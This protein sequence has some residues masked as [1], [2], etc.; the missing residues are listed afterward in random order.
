MKAAALLFSL[1]AAAPAAAG[2]KIITFAPGIP[3]EARTRAVESRGG[4]VLK[5]FNLIN[6][7]LADMPDTA[8]GADIARAPGVDAA[9]DD[10]EIY[11]LGTDA[12][13]PLEQAQAALDAG[14]P[15]PAQPPAA[16]TPAA[17]AAPPYVATTTA[18]GG[19]DRM[20]W[21]AWRLQAP[22]AWTKARGAGARVAVLDT[23]T[24]CSH[25]D[26]AAA[27]LPGYNAQAPG[28]EPFDDG[29]H[30]THVSGIIAGALN[31][32]G[33]VGLAP[34]ARIIPVKVLN[35]SGTGKIS[36]ILDGMEWAVAQKPDIMNMSLGSPNY[37]EAQARAVKA[38]RQAGILVVCAA[39]NSGGP[40]GYPAA[41]EDS[42]AV[43]AMD[44][45]NKLTDFSC[46]GPEIDFIAPGYKIFSA[47]PGGKFMLASGTSQAAPHVSGVA[48]LGAGLGLKGEALRAALIKA[49][50][51]VGLPPEQQGAGAPVASYL[52]RDIL[53]PAGR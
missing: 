1:L 41:Y 48:A 13:E 31:G 44:F 27:C 19:I 8:R 43:A 51:N 12:A 29:G 37:S 18:D 3:P 40:V 15:Q 50:Y 38:A 24:D 6:A 9:E 21:G 10:R 14:T 47:A 26:L 52:V 34:E 7:V 49:S 32:K 2:Q 46:R 28:T 20:P 53:M 17:P 33:M 11:W 35:S 25:P 5:E 39:G 4:K 45:S 30:G 22:L 36:Q 42:I 23:G 16:S